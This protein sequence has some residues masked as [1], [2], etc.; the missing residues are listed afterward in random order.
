MNRLSMTTVAAAMALLAGGAAL[1]AEV[2]E[3]RTRAEV[4]AERDAAQAAGTIAALVGED[5]GDHHLSQQRWIPSRSRA[6]VAAELSQSRRSGEL[7]AMTGEDSGAHHLAQQTVQPQTHYVGPNHGAE[8]AMP[9]R[10]AAGAAA[11]RS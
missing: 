11:K 3:G 6:E 9:V 5:S 8:D 7:A 4:I 2:D 1:A 10:Q